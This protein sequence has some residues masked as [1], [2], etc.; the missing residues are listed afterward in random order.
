MPGVV[1]AGEA[2]VNGGGATGVESNFAAS[3][4]SITEAEI[5]DGSDADGGGAGIWRGW[6][7][8]AGAPR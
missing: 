8:T 6:P 2:A 5:N 3:W 1:V 4:P 7:D